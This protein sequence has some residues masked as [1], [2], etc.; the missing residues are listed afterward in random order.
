M[1]T[2][3]R[4]VAKSDH[5]SSADLEDMI[6]KGMDL[7][8]TIK[9]VRQQFG[10]T[11]AGQKI[12]ANIAYFNESIKPLVLNATNGKVLSKFA[13]SGFIEDWAGLDIELFIDHNV[14]FKGTVVDG[15]RIKKTKPAPSK[16]KD[17][18]LKLINDCTTKVELNPLRPYIAKYGL[19]EQAN[20]KAAKL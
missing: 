4:T 6:E 16:T 15:V 2:H 11:V 20:K 8:F 13:N 17:E 10:A 9:E 5:L 3:Y 19:S 14:K 18:V 7:I 1:K 12:D